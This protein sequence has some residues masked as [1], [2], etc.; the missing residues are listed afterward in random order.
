MLKYKNGVFSVTTLIAKRY[1]ISVEK[2]RNAG[3][4]FDGRKKIWVT[5]FWKIA[6]KLDTQILEGS[7]QHLQNA[8]HDSSRLTNLHGFNVPLPDGKTLFG[9]QKAGIQYMLKN[10]RV[11]LADQMGLGKT[12]QVIGLLNLLQPSRVLIIC[13]ASLRFNWSNELKNWLKYDEQPKQI[14]VIAYSKLQKFQNMRAIKWDIVIIDEAHY[15]KNKK[16]QRTK[17]ITEN[18]AANRVVALTGTPVVNRPIELFSILNYLQPELFPSELSFAQRY[19]RAHRKTIHIKDKK[20]RIVK[21]IIWDFSGA[22]ELTELNEYIRSILMIRRT[23]DQILEQLPEKTRQF[24]LVDAESLKAEQIISD[25]NNLIL[26]LYGPK[27]AYQKAAGDLNNCQS[28]SFSKL[29]TVRKA[30]VQKKMPFIIEHVEQAINSSKKVICFC[31]H[32]QTANSLKNYF[33][34]KACVFIGSTPMRLREKAV[35]DFQLNP[36]IK[37]FIGSIN[38]A[39]IGITLTASSNVIFAEPSW[40]P[41]RLEQAEDRVHRIGQK[42]GVL[43][44][45]L[46]I[47]NSLEGRMIQQVFDKQAVIDKLTK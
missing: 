16:A 40:V 8:N 10:K 17:F 26:K 29:S 20:G 47:K 18:I 41:G 14:E 15:I 12:I 31:H 3:F 7:L 25:E 22:S 36:D 23:K 46:L 34:Q 4:M 6:A 28:P 19:C 27:N 43:I 42:R 33:G 30:L 13:P 38:A 39:G 9:Y 2:L 37:L 5:G 32:V 44:Q 1:N 35:T 21:K 45:Y 24:I 11:L